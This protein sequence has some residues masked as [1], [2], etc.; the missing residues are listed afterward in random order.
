[1]RVK[2]RTSWRNHT[3]NQSIDPLRIY[4]P[5]SSD[6]L[7]EIVLEGER[8]GYPV[9]AVGSGHSWSD[10]AL[11]PGFLV[12]TSSLPALVD[13]NR[14][15]WRAGAE[16]P[17]ARVGAGMRLREVNA[18]L[19]AAGLALPNM[20]GYDGQTVAGVISTSTHGSGVSF[21]P[22]SDLVRSLDLVASGGERYRIEPADGPTDPERFIGARL[23]QDDHWFRAAAV[24]MG[25]L[26]L[27]HAVTLAVE[28][29]Y[30]LTERRTQSTWEEV[31]EILRKRDVLEAHR[32]Y[33]VYLNPHQREGRN[34]CMITTRDRAATIPDRPPDRQ[35][36]SIPEF[37]ATLAITPHVLNLIT[38]L[39]PAWSPWLLDRALLALAD[40]EF[41]SASYKVL[42][43]GTA[44]LL[45]AYSAEIGVP[46]DDRGSHVRA[47]DRIIEIADEHR[48]IGGVYHTSPIA[49][50][51]VK[52]SE[53]YLSMMEGRMTM[54]IELIQMTRTE[55]GVELLDA[56][57]RGLDELA[58]GARPHWGQI[59]RL[60]REEIEG[61]YPH[62][63]DWLDIHGRLNASG[64]FGGPFARRVGFEELA[65]PRSVPAP[66]A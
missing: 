35:R 2:T 20:G 18:G 47:V 48:R 54:M 41:T 7:I 65:V 4:W 51:V 11:T 15:A 45:P 30:A 40:E 53:K 36:N 58:I 31:R 57:E 17:L 44:N 28:G 56:Y 42:N 10:V 14:S 33:E 25:C 61:A 38:D 50:R 29:S 24:G 43:I 19:D 37:I 22:L 23:V 32:H 52:A 3:G 5:E 12:E 49:L 62:L 55:G 46:V 27:I 21:G 64:V 9:R 39:R 16:Q 60:N 34:L 6:D 59:N 8:L 66:D 63:G 1:V 26:G 13:T